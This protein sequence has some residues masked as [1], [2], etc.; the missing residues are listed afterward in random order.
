[1]PFLGGLEYLYSVNKLTLELPD[2]TVDQLKRMAERLGTP[3]ESL[4]TAS[5]AEL[6]SRSDEQFTDMVRRVLEKNQELY[7]RLA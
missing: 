3:V 1:L 5:V 7:R 4:A 6:V 2:E